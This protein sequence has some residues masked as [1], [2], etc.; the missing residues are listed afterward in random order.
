M[1]AQ[2]SQLRRDPPAASARRAARHAE[3]TGSLACSRPVRVNSSWSARHQWSRAR[4][5]ADAAATTAGPR[6]GSG[7][8][9]RAQLASSSA[10]SRGVPPAAVAPASSSR[11][12]AAATAS[13]PS[14]EVS[15]RAV[16]T[17]MGPPRIVSPKTAL[18]RLAGATGRGAR[19]YHR[20][21]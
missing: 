19:S 12:V 18:A 15:Q 16:E 9:S 6:P 8:R 17:S 14:A 13:S 5:R 7:H 2:R 3:T 11:S 4:R 21:W 1:P 20:A 10:G